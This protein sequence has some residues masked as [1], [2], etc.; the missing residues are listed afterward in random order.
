MFLHSVL[1][2]PGAAANSVPS[3]TLY[4]LQ[5]NITPKT[6]RNLQSLSP[7]RYSFDRNQMRRGPH[8]ELYCCKDSWIGCFAYRGIDV[9]RCR[10]FHHWYCWGMFLIAQ[11]SWFSFL[12]GTLTSSVGLWLQLVCS[13]GTSEEWNS[14]VRWQSYLFGFDFQAIPI[15]CRAV[16]SWDVPC[17]LFEFWTQILASV[18]VP[19]R[20]L[21]NRF[22]ASSC[23]IW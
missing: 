4:S 9:T 15:L 1:T 2:L 8:L 17:K 22:Q 13:V 7:L 18:V 3:Y 20:T 5:W 14:S 16:V 19:G 6:V 21:G 12:A 23:S 10:V 11:V